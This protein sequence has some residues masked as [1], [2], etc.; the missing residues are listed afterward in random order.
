VTGRFRVPSFTR[1]KAYINAMQIALKG[2]KRK[3]VATVAEVAKIGDGKRGF[4]VLLPK[5][6]ICI[7]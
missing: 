1:I 2:M 5:M 7:Y 4:G 6:N 3:Q